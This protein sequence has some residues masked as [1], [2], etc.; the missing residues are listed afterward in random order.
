MVKH[1]LPASPRFMQGAKQQ[2]ERA[3]ED[4][5]ISGLASHITDMLTNDDNL[6]IIWGS[7]GT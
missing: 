2:V 6:M 3:S 4:E 7:G 5:V 1:L